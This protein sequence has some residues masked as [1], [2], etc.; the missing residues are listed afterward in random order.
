MAIKTIIHLSTGDKFTCSLDENTRLTKNL[1]V[2]EVANNLAVEEVKLEIYPKSW[3][4]FEM[5]QFIRDKRGKA[6]TVTS[7]HRTPTFNASL[8]DASPKSLHLKT[9]ALDIII[10]YDEQ[11]PVVNWVY[12]FTLQHGLIGGV[13]R[14]PD[15]M[16]I[17]VAEDEFGYKDFVIRNKKTGAVHYRPY[18]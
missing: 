14:Y 2:H 1:Q 4:L 5:F 12:L 16:H 18:K 6:I 3:L 7:G 13:N 11:E 9:Y 15:R 10:P 17:D 8:K